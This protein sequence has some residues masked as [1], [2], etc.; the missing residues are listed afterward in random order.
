MN[1]TCNEFAVVSPVTNVAS[2]TS[3]LPW[4]VWVLSSEHAP[5]ALVPL[6]DRFHLDA[7]STSTLPRQTWQVRRSSR[8]ASPPS[9]EQ[10]LPSRRKCSPS[11]RVLPPKNTPAS[12]RG[13]RF[14]MSEVPLYQRLQLLASF[15]SLDHSLY[16]DPQPVKCGSLHARSKLAPRPESPLLPGAPPPQ[17][18]TPEPTSKAR[19][20][21]TTVCHHSAATLVRFARISG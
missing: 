16:R 15:H 6:P 21:R 11:R 8:G 4:Q 1:F 9:K 3:T 13:R 12:P 5:T 7:G 14:L 18:Y 2:S 20:P 17:K 10:A 19:R